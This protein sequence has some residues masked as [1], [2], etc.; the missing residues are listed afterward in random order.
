LS[1]HWWARMRQANSLSAEEETDREEGQR[2]RGKEITRSSK[3]REM[4]LK[5]MLAFLLEF[6]RY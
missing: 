4:A 2:T 3:I 6:I 1:D 5:S